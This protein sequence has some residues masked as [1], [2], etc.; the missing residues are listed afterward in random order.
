VAADKADVV[1]LGRLDHLLALFHRHCHWLGGDDVLAMVRGRDCVLGVERGRRYDVDCVDIGALAHLL[2]GGIALDVVIGGESLH[3]VLAYIGCCRQ[4]D[5]RVV[6]E[7][8]EQIHGAGP[9]ARDAEAKR[10][11]CHADPHALGLQ[12]LLP[13]GDVCPNGQ[14]WQP[15]LPVLAANVLGGQGVQAGCPV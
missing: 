12:L 5:V 2:Y 3:R 14:G 8:A 13:A 1:A 10:L 9:E 7:A 11:F 4:L 6:G 15:M